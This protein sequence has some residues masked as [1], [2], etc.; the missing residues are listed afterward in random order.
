MVF[1][2][3]RAGQLVRFVS[4]AVMTGFLAGV[5]MLLILDQS[6]PFVGI[7]VEGRNGVTEFLNLLARVSEF[8][9]STMVTGS[10]ALVLAFGLGALWSETS[11]Q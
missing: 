1:G 4:H 6:A 9:A 2:L 10:M 11:L 5:A 8:S 7:H 3:F